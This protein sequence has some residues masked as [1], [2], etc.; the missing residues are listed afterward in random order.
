MTKEDLKQIENLLDKKLDEKLKP[1]KD[2]IVIIKKDIKRID[3]EVTYHS[4]KLVEIE[5]NQAAQ[6]SVI[7]QL[8]ESITH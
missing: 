8:T 6:T 7:N 2:D 1:I 3:K 4:H 5:E